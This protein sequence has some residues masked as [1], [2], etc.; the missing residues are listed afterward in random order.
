[1]VV[2]DFLNRLGPVEMYGKCHEIPNPGNGSASFSLMST[3]NFWLT[4]FFVISEFGDSVLMS[5][6][7]FTLGFQKNK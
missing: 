5:L 4:L 1:M 3:Q 6:D 2:N 7:Q